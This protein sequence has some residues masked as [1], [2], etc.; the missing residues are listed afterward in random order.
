MSF[1]VSPSDFIMFMNALR[2]L[3]QTLRRGAMESFQRHVRTYESFAEVATHLDSLAASSDAKLNPLFRRTRRDIEK[4]L[5]TFFKKIEKFQP[6]LGSGRKRGSFMGAI[7]KIKWSQ[8]EKMLKDLRHDLES[9]ISNVNLAIQTSTRATIQILPGFSGLGPIPRPLV[10]NQFVLED[11][12]RKAHPLLFAN[13]PNWEY[14]HEFLL[15]VFRK[16]PGLRAVEARCYMLH[17]ASTGQDILPSSPYVKSLRDLIA[18]DER[19]EMSVIFPTEYSYD[20]DSNS[21]VSD[22]DEDVTSSTDAERCP[23]CKSGRKN[24][25]SVVVTCHHCGFVARFLDSFEDKADPVTQ[26]GIGDM[27]GSNLKGLVQDFTAEVTENGYLV[28]N[29]N[30]LHLKNL[31]RKNIPG[32]NAG[33]FTEALPMPPLQNFRRVTFCTSRWPAF[34]RNSRYCRADKQ[35]SATMNHL[36]SHL[37]EIKAGSD[38]PIESVAK[39]IGSRFAG[40]RLTRRTEQF[41]QDIYSQYDTRAQRHLQTMHIIPVLDAYS[42]SGQESIYQFH[43]AVVKVRCFLWSILQILT[44]EGKL[45]LGCSNALKCLFGSAALGKKQLTKRSAFGKVFESIFVGHLLVWRLSFDL[46]EDAASMAGSLFT[47]N[48]PPLVVFAAL[49]H[50]LKQSRRLCI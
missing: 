18:L 3:A 7:A 19:I 13:I 42:Q 12:R 31:V 35:L 29:K 30:A 38:S 33:D 5:K 24:T 46:V 28:G 20:D 50:I 37:D 8:H 27:R 43:P 10:G 16:D 15:R 22:A 11:A 41:L 39:V 47:E 44:L 23:R 49:F 34:R 26:L 1:G 40:G 32:S 4:L 9:R 45:F 48:S 21:G 2:T 36:K 25:T 17:N 6:L 14:L